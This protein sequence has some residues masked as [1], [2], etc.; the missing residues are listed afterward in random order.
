MLWPVMKC[1]GVEVC[2][3]WPDDRVNFG[4]DTDFGKESGITQRTKQLALQNR[5]EINGAR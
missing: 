1:S 4:I 2:A 5:L 3:G